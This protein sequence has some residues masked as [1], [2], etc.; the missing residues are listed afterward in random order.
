MIV[1][2][3]GPCNEAQ[4]SLVS[5]YCA[6]DYEHEMKEIL[7]AEETETVYEERHVFLWPGHCGPCLAPFL[8]VCP[9]LFLCK[10][11]PDGGCYHQCLVEDLV[12]EAVILYSNKDSKDISKFSRLTNTVFFLSSIFFQS[13]SL[14]LQDNRLSAGYAKNIWR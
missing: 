14:I 3:L 1:L 9:S 11:D 13:S 8:L 7:T 5:D 6:V 2:A 12:V 10:V 4:F